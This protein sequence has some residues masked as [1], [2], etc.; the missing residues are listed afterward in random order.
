MEFYR[1]FVA[2]PVKVSEAF[3]EVHGE[4][5]KSLTSE[6]ISW[7]DPKRYHVTLRFL[8]DIKV[9]DIGNICLGLKEGVV[10]PDKSFLQLSQIG[11]FGPRKKPRVVWVGFENTVI[12]EDLK[13][14]VDG[15]LQK[16]GIPLSVQ[17]F[18]AHLTLGRVRSLKDLIG[19]YKVLAD[20]KDKFNELVLIDKL[21]FY[22]SNLGSGGPVY[23]PLYQKPFQ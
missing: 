17:P 11:S 22:R 21:V 15:A 4:L 9:S 18:R 20:M 5:I 2:L 12:F 3:L 14:G 23:T 16:C 1:T 7:V 13:V 19:F 6:R 8:G 10:V